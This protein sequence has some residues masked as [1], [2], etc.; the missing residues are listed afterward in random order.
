MT[1]SS[2]GYTAANIQTLEGLEA[3]QERPGMYI[4]STGVNGLHHLVYEVVDNSIDE[5]LAGHCDA[6]RIVIHE[7]NS[8]TVEDNGRGI[9]IDKNEDG[10]P[11]I[12]VI[13][14]VL[15][16]GGKFDSEAYGVS[17]GLH[18]VG[19]SCVNALSSKLEVSVRRDG[20]H[21]SQ[22]Y[23]DTRPGELVQGEA[24][25][26]DDETGTSVRFW[27]NLDILE[28]DEYVYDTLNSRIQNLA[29]L[30]PG[31]EITF[32]DERPD[33]KTENVYY[34]EGG[35]REF[36]K[37]LNT[38]KEPIHEDIP[39][40]SSEETTDEGHNVAVDIA[41]Q[42]TTAT[43]QSDDGLLSFANNIETQEGGTHLTGFKQATTRVLNA[44]AKDNELLGNLDESTLSGTF[45]REGLTAVISIKHSDP[46]FEGQTKTKLGN[47]SVRGVV[48]GVVSE[49]FELYLDENPDTAERIIEKAVQAAMASKAAK[50]AEELTRRDSPLSSTG[51]PGKLADCQSKDPAESELFLVEGAS[52]GGSAKQGRDP[53]FQS[54]LPLRGKII[55]PE[56][57]RLDRIL[58]NNE[59]QDLITAIGAGVG[60]DFDVEDARYHKIIT[61]TDADVDG[62]HIR[63]LLLT[64]LYRHMRPL[65][66][67]GFVYK[68]NPPLYRLRYGAQT[69][70]AMTDTERDEIIESR[71]EPDRTQRFKGLGEMNPEQLWSTTMNPETRYLERLTVEEAAEADKM[72]SILM[73]TDV[74]PRREFI[75]QNAGEVEWVD[76]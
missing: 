5:A 44:Y 4:G 19:I 57:H 13:M 76:I 12:E 58:K 10:R 66:D 63:T 74:E 72:F 64:L 71:G 56:K 3:V 47:A 28:T 73:G 25:R 27:P 42:Y 18:G 49:Q 38:A 68:A 39:L 65:I 40:F 14:T 50:K 75:Q 21:W 2:T 11:A 7:D 36:V 17:G 6:I 16:A 55:N 8:V 9:P 24:L 15:H 53:E 70:D 52:A 61:L 48:S 26:D 35:I 30:N 67:A 33:K 32:T 22:E 60:E 43:T 62:A 31:V 23:V 29:Y 46:Q 20:Y 51:L 54:I 37:D 45:V 34:Y 1:D 69:V 41:L 59:V